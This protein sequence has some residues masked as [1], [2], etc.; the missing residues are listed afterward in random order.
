MLGSLEGPIV[1]GPS[2][3]IESFTSTDQTITSAG[4]LTIAHGLSAAPN[5]MQYY[6]V[7]QVAEHNY[8]IGDLLRISS[9]A[10]NANNMSMAVV[11][12]STNIKVRFGSGTPVFK[13][14]DFTTGENVNL[15]N[16]SWEVR[17]IATI[18]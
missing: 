10:A 4:S 5:L 7:C 13:G 8:S 15:T 11:T 3:V 9:D 12:D 17:F 2:T 18:V 14:L 16:A 1:V 6:L